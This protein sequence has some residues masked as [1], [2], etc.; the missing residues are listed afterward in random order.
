[1]IAARMAAIRSELLAEV[2]G[3]ALEIGFGTGLNL[4]H[5]PEQ[6]RRITT[7]DPNPGMDKPTRR[8]VAASDIENDRRSAIRSGIRRTPS[9][10]SITLHR[11]TTSDLVVARS[12]LTS[13]ALGA[14][15]LAP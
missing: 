14:V 13:I 9:S 10:S 3:E 2:S 11:G 1:M 5:H 7:V 8:R 6:V 12:I 4:P 15:K